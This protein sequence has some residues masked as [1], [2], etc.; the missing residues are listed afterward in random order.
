M[1]KLKLQDEPCSA[2]GYTCGTNHKAWCPKVHPEMWSWL[3]RAKV[4]HASKEPFFYEGTA[5]TRQELEG[6]FRTWVAQEQEWKHR[7][8]GT[9]GLQ[10]FHLFQQ[11]PHHHSEYTV[12][13]THGC[14]LWGNEKAQADIIQAWKQARGRYREYS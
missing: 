8:T 11:R 10:V 9:F 13:F 14:E 7:G 3:L 12:S 4:G 2:C 5:R 6:I 1:K